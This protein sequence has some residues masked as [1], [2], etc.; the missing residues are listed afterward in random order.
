[1]VDLHAALKPLTLADQRRVVEFARKMPLLSSV[2]ACVSPLAS[3]LSGYLT[4]GDG[5]LMDPD[6]ES[7]E[8]GADGLAECKDMGLCD[9]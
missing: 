4:R 1:M 6:A 9:P 3:T 8:I 2:S 5:S 7:L